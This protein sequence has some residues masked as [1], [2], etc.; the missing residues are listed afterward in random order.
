MVHIA[1]DK[2][3]TDFAIQHVESLV[4]KYVTVLFSSVTVFHMFIVLINILETVDK[5]SEVNTLAV[6]FAGYSN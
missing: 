2:C 6:L 1:A 3:N 5:I 4:K